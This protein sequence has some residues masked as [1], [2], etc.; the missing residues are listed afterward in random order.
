MVL[1]LPV[2]AMP[3]T[4][5]PNS[6]GA[7]MDLI[8]RRKMVPR[9]RHFLRGSRENGAERDAGDQADQNP[10]GEGGS[11][12]R[13][14]YKS[15]SAQKSARKKGTDRSVHCRSGFGVGRRVDWGQ[16]SLSPF[17]ARF[18]ARHIDFIY[19]PISVFR[20]GRRRT[21]WWAAGSDW[22]RIRSGGS[23]PNRRASTIRRAGRRW[24][25]RFS[26]VR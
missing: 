4:S 6:S 19:R 8:R 11:L 5:V 21:A 9:M 15:R 10:G 23:A 14:R 2:P 26:H 25:D 1:M 16:S 17:C 7:M 13:E 20:A 12:H 22:W 24:S 3:T 18:F